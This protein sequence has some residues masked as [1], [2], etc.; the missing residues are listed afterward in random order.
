[1]EPTASAPATVTQ[2]TPSPQPS[3]GGALSANSIIVTLFTNIVVGF[4]IGIGFIL[5][6]K[7][8]K[9]NISVDQKQ[10]SN[11]MSANGNPSVM[12]P[13]RTRPPMGMPQRPPFGYVPPYANGYHQAN[14]SEQTFSIDSWLHGNS[15]NNIKTEHL[16]SVPD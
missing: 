9:K 12:Y 3:G 6:Q 14:G 5:A 1:M 15:S 11:T 10:D 13:P 4:A 16:V 8:T 2:S 7:A